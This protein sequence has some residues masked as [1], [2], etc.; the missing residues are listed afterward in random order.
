[1][2]RV[3]MQSLMAEPQY[4]FPGLQVSVQ[5]VRASGKIRLVWVS[6]YLRGPLADDTK[7]IVVK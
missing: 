1:M 5:L 2:G 4:T 6:R 3:L 7:V